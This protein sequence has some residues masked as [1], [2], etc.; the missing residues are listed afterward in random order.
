MRPCAGQSYIDEARHLEQ[1]AVRQLQEAL[2]REP[3]EDP[4][5]R[6]RYFQQELMLGTTALKEG[7]PSC[8]AAHLDLSHA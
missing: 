3:P 5:E 2:G 6:G 8:A 4:M 1:E 7:A